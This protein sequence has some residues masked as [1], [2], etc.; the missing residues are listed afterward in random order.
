MKLQLIVQVWYDAFIKMVKSAKPERVPCLNTGKEWQRKQ[1]QISV[2]PTWRV[3]IKK[4]SK[5][6]LLTI[7]T[8]T[9]QVCCILK[10]LYHIMTSFQIK[11]AQ[12]SKATRITLGISTIKCTCCHR[13]PRA[14]ALMAAFKITRPEIQGTKRQCG[15]M[16]KMPGPKSSLIFLAR[17]S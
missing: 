15:K 12:L 13:P 9:V 1:H 3:F 5:S 17:V 6:L 14:N 7:K 8:A 2:A 10:S 16:C 4:T 11:L